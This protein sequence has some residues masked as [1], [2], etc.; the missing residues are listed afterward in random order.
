MQR[1]QPMGIMQ[2][3]EKITAEITEQNGVCWRL[4]GPSG[5]D[6]YLR[7][8]HIDL[9]KKR[10]WRDL[11][12]KDRTRLAFDQRPYRATVIGSRRPEKTLMGPHYF[13]DRAGAA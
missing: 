6:D 9:Q 13:M 10:D 7:Y 3:S 12:C 5:Q 4:N 11:L 2:R 1:R 8:D